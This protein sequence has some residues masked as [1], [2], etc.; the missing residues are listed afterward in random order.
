[1]GSTTDPIVL[2]YRRRAAKS[3]RS[4]LTAVR[5]WCIEC[6]GG[7]VAEVARCTEGGP[8]VPL[9]SSCPLFNFR[10]GRNSG[11]KSEDEP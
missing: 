8:Y 11:P 5:A 2:K 4:V 9:E 3:R 1:M 10:M 7:Q 6:M